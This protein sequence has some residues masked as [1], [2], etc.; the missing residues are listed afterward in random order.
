MNVNEF[1]VDYFNVLL[2]KPSKGKK[3]IFLLGNFNINSLN[4]DTNPSSN[5]FLN[6]ILSHYSPPIY[7][8]RDKI[9]N[10]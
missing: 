2:D 7:Y 4:Y 5:V 3:T 9:I 10:I 6:L 8:K 1:N